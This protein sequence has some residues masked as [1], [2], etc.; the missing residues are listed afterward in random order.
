METVWL[1]EANEKQRS[2]HMV[3]LLWTKSRRACLTEP[4]ASLRGEPPG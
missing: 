3:S 4:S 1:M 2:G